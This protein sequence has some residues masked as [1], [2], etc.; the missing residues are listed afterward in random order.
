MS[1]GSDPSVTQC[2]ASNG[3]AIHEDFALFVKD[4]NL[5]MQLHVGSAINGKVRHGSQG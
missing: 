4:F 2:L 5:A 1:S 3:T